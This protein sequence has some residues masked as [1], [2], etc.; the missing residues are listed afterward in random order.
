VPVLIVLATLA[1]SVAITTYRFAVVIIGLLSRADADY[2]LFV[3]FTSIVG[4]VSVGVALVAVRG[5]LRGARYAPFLV[6]LNALWDASTLV[7]YGDA[8]AWLSALLSLVAVV[9]VWLP[10]TRSFAA[11]TRSARQA[12]K[13]LIGRGRRQPLA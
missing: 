4:L 7:S 10:A 1:L 8:V 6:T 9:T 12:S 11:D 13:G 2:S 3:V 5:V